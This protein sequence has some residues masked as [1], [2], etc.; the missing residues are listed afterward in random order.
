LEHGIG[1]LNRDVELAAQYLVTPVQVSSDNYYAT[2][3]QPLMEADRINDNTVRDVSQ[4]S[5]PFHNIVSAL[6]VLVFK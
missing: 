3:A 5:H 1:G 4:T 6:I 2:G